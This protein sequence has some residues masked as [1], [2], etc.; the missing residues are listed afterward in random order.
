MYTQGHGPSLETSAVL[1]RVTVS[2]EPAV[3]FLIEGTGGGKASPVY[4][5]SDGLTRG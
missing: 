5:Q 1:D 3:S 2:N 4:E